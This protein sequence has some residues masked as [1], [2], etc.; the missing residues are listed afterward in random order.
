MEKLSRF[1]CVQ[2]MNYFFQDS[3]KSKQAIRFGG[4]LKKQTD[5]VTI[6]L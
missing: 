4:F 2:E 1:Q 5:Y 6:K 3:K